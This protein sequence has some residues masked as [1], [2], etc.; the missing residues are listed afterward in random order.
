MLDAC[1]GEIYVHHLWGHYFFLPGLPFLPS[2]RWHLP[3][4]DVKALL[5]TIRHI[6]R[7]LWTLL[8]DFQEGFD[9]NM[10]VGAFAWS[11]S[12]MSH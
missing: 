2:K 11:W 1:K 3:F 7:L 8:L 9:E 5:L 10:E 12:L 6:S 4:K